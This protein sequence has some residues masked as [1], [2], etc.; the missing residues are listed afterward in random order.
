M[1][2]GIRISVCIPTYAMDGGVEFLKHSLD[3]LEK[4]SFKNFEVVVSDNSDGD[5]I[6]NLCFPYSFVK[7]YRNPK[8]GSSANLNYAMSKAKGDIIKILFQDDYLLG[9]DALQIINN[10]FKPTDKWL[11]TAC[12]HTTDGINLTRPFYPRYNPL[13]QF[14]NN[15]ISSPSVLAVRNKRHLEFD[16]NLKWLMDVDYYKRCYD[17]FGEPCIVD[18]ITVVNRVGSHQVSASISRETIDKEL[19]YAHKKHD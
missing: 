4:Q 19:A 18:V 14:G 13:I 10:H 3:I 12:E 5:E 1:D 7:Y 9:E 17:A 6:E 8:K 15:T 11:V 2:K 16:E